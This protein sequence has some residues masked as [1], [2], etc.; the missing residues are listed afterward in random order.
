ML[1]NFRDSKISLKF[2]KSGVNDKSKKLNAR[3]FEI[4]LAGGFLLPEYYP[5]VV[6][7]FKVSD[8]IDIF[9]S[10]DECIHKFKYYLDN[11]GYREAIRIRGS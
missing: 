11:Q 10:P 1:Q 7:Y 5:E 8:E 2:T 9:S 6:S 3:A 4:M